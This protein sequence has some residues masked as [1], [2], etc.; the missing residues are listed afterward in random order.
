MNSRRKFLQNSA[1]VLGGG[2]LASLLT[3]ML[4]QFL[5]IDRSERPVKYRRNRGERNGL[6]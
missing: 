5:K 6:G 3:T 4:L 1:V 2:L